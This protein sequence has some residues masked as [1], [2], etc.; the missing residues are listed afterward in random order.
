MIDT[1]K[2]DKS[3]LLFSIK[4]NKIYEYGMQLVHFSQTVYESLETKLSM[5]KIK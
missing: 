4:M 3:E 2:I 1:K 5:N